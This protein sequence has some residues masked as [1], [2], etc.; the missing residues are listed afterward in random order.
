MADVGRPSG[1]RPEYCEQVIEW[2]KQG[3]SKAWMAS[4]LDISRQTLDNWCDANPE[5]L[6]AMTR[7]RAHAQAW[8]EDQG[9]AYMLMPQGAG[10]FNASVWSRSMA[11]RFPEDWRE[12]TSTELTGANG[13]PVQIVATE[14]DEN[15]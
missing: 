8:W 4:Q 12:K 6:D 15:L 13:G 1:Y 2:G 11:A 9:Q 7:A 3:K 10:T 5:F 14:H